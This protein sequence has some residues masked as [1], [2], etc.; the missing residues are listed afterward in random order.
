MLM[1]KMAGLAAEEGEDPGKADN[2]AAAEVGQDFA[3]RLD[4][5]PCKPYSNA[6]LD[7]V[8]PAQKPL[9]AC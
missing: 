6:T 7:H 3:Y 2:L 9:M 5:T 8:K 4:D 1:G